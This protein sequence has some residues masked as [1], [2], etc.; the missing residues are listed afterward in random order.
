[1]AHPWPIAV[2]RRYVRLMTGRIGLL[3]AAVLEV[4]RPLA[5]MQLDS[6]RLD[7]DSQ[8]LI[9][10]IDVVRVKVATGQLY[11]VGTGG[12]RALAKQID[13]FAGQRVDRV[14]GRIPTISANVLQAQAV[15]DLD[16]WALE[17]VARIKT[18]D[19]RYFDDVQ[20]MVRE[21]VV[22]GTRSA[23]LA[24]LIMG[25]VPQETRGR[26]SAE[27]NARRIARDQLGSLNGKLTR[28]RYAGANVARYRWATMQDEVVRPVHR[29]LNGQVFDV[30]GPGAIGAGA[31]GQDIHPGDDIQCRC[32]MIPVFDEDGE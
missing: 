16:A 21:A 31:F 18:I 14:V 8:A 13:L 2:E 3:E 29:Q 7:A 9:K 28:K 24:R 15:G 12:V 11:E 32:R 19:Q 30:G 4:V 10:A 17:Q 20:E 5:E 6:R 26:T 23:D 25:R 22:K 1:L 27:S